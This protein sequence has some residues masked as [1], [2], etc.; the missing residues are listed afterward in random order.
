MNWP[1]PTLADVFKA[2]R[3]ISPYLSRT[4]VL[5]PAGLAAALGCRA[6]LKC[7]NLNP[8]GA[9]KV[10]GGVNL[11][12]S[13]EPEGRARGVVAASTGNHGQSIAYAARLFG[14]P[15]TIFMPEAANPLKAAATVAMGAEVIRTGRDFDAA[16]LSAEEHAARSWTSLHPFVERA[17]AGRRGRHGGAGV[18]RG[19]PR[20]RC[21]L[22]PGGRRQRGARGRRGGPRG[23][24]GDPGR[25]RAGR[26][27]A[28]GLSLVAR[29]TS[30]R[31]RERDHVRRGARDP[32]AIRDATGPIPQP[33]R[34]DDARR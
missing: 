19:G 13:L 25:R 23:Q 16:R 29:G 31:H 11:L 33:G 7:E 15:A 3:A 18:T 24:P 10:R 1:T 30:R 6:V 22:R 17:L 8:T 14:T 5:E 27:R 9:F 32:G 20:D 28:G 26:R 12:A 4:P 21:D 34:R 2:R